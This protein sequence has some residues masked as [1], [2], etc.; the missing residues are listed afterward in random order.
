[1]V[2][3]ISALTYF[4]GFGILWVP[5]YCLGL[6]PLTL[7]VLLW[8]GGKMIETGLKFLEPV[9]VSFK[10]S[11]FLNGGLFLMTAICQIIASLI[12]THYDF[13]LYSVF[14]YLGLFVSFTVIFALTLGLLVVRVIQSKRT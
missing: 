11:A 7:I 4:T 14:I 9:Q 6:F 12:I 5:L 2:G 1:M 3:S 13:S 10:Y 8:L